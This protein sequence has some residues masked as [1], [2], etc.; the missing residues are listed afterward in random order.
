M[1]GEEGDQPDA[2]SAGEG[3]TEQDRHALITML[4]SIAD[5][6]NYGEEHARRV[7][8]TRVAGELA[9]IALQLRNTARDLDVAASYEP[10]QEKLPLGV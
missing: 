8:L 9:A 1:E 6:C 10:R 5:R 4:R 2:R 7:G 3:V